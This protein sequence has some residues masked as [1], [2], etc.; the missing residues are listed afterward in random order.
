MCKYPKFGHNR[1]RERNK[2]WAQ[3]CGRSMNTWAQICS[4]KTQDFVFNSGRALCKSGRAQGSS[5]RAQDSKGRAQHP[6]KYASS[7]STG[8]VCA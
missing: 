2:I 3:F 6:H 4:L 8:D 5:G 7:W 1:A